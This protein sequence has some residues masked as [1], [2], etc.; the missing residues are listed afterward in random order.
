MPIFGNAPKMTTAYEQDLFLQALHH[1]KRG[2][3]IIFGIGTG[4]VRAPFPQKGR[5]YTKGI[6]RDGCEGG[7]EIHKALFP[8][9]SIKAVKEK[10]AKAG[11]DDN[12][13][14]S[15][16]SIRE[17]KHHWKDHQDF[18]RG[19]MPK[20]YNYET[21]YMG[22]CLA[23][24]VSDKTKAEIVAT[25][26]KL[27]EGAYEEGLLPVPSMVTEEGANL[28]LFYNLATS[29]SV[30]DRPNNAEKFYADIQC[31]LLEKYQAV[32]EKL[33]CHQEKRIASGGKKKLKQKRLTPDV[34]T[35]YP[36][37]LARIP[38]TKSFDGKEE[39]HITSLNLDEKG[40]LKYY[41]LS[42]LAIRAPRK[43][44]DRPELK[45]ETIV[46]PFLNPRIQKL[47][48]I[49]D[50][51]GASMSEEE[52]KGMCK[53]VYSALRETHGY[54]NAEA[55][56]LAFNEGFS[57]PLSTVALTRV[58]DGAL[59]HTVP[60]GKYKGLVGAYPYKDET[61]IKMLHITDEEM[62]ETG[63]GKTYRE[64]LEREKRRRE[65]D[66]RRTLMAKDILHSDL[67]YAEIA[68]KYEVSKKT[69]N[70]LAGEL[71]IGRYKGEA[72]ELPKEI[73]GR[74]TDKRT[75]AKQKMAEEKVAFKT[76]I[77]LPDPCAERERGEFAKRPKS[78]ADKATYHQYLYDWEMSTVYGMRLKKVE[79]EFCEFL[80]KF[81]PINLFMDDD[82]GL[83]FTERFYLYDNKD[84]LAK[85]ECARYRFS[86]SCR[87][88]HPLVE[89]FQSCFYEGNNSLYTSA[90]LAA[91]I[92]TNTC[93]R[94][95]KNAVM[96]KQLKESKKD[97]APWTEVDHYDFGNGKDTPDDETDDPGFDCELPD[98]EWDGFV[99]P[100]DESMW[101]HVSKGP[102]Y[103]PDYLEKK[104]S[105]KAK[106]TKVL[107]L[108]GVSVQ[109][110]QMRNQT[111]RKHKGNTG[112]KW[113]NRTELDEAWEIALKNDPMW[114]ERCFIPFDSMDGFSW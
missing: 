53:A 27:L 75:E 93:T 109:K 48:A 103:Q 5:L 47:G 44:T 2:G 112:R 92:L 99:L 42:E 95:E 82:C 28:N 32:L 11:K 58:M 52:K 14:V 6:Y 45:E 29:I 106:R 26:K 68:E 54:A 1:D 69:V 100:P 16:N 74:K 62:D 73:P 63:F 25:S 87:P 7:T 111:S 56:L 97:E 20:I 72:T 105:K 3:Q 22:L 40:R 13:Y 65:R 88:K 43:R 38:G 80:P 34:W 64:K 30:S 57:E 17:I 33:P 19:I 67:T 70:R 84:M 50:K 114:K 8:C 24:E 107:E 46:L 83:T 31:R 90:E 78:P 108:S 96:E 12:L 9:A 41:T 37:A 18:Q 94:G 36:Y 89:K 55:K 35:L 85:T 110:P 39:C 71:N 21:I 15:V 59:D 23:K 49:R 66:E 81:D 91:K 77:K 86:A 104:S 102:F 98:P 4:F 60:K 101:N 51:R 61:I 113:A 79:R 76:T 10:M